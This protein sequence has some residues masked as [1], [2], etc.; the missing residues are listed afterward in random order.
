MTFPATDA[1]NTARVHLAISDASDRT[2]VV[3]GGGT[4]IYRVV[5][6]GL[7]KVLQDK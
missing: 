1:G 3:V 5:G 7:I 4:A 6:A 2:S